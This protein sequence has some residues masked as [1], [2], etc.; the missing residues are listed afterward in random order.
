MNISIESSSSQSSDDTSFPESS[1]FQ[2]DPEQLDD[3][4]F[5]EHISQTVNDWLAQHGKAL[6]ALET[7]KYLVKINKE[8]PKTPKKKDPYWDKP[9]RDHADYVRSFCPPRDINS[10]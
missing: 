7:S 9:R 2:P 4:Y 1:A 3:A 5:E 10:K 6:F 8:M